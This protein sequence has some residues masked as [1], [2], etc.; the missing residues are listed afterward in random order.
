MRRG[1]KY[2]KILAAFAIPR[3]H[4]QQAKTKESAAWADLASM[5]QAFEDYFLDCDNYPH[6]TGTKSSSSGLQHLVI[7]ADSEATWAGPYMKFKK[8]T[9][10]WPY[11]PWHQPYEYEGSNGSSYTIWCKG[12]GYTSDYSTTYINP[13]LFKSP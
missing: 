4:T 10:N 13:G 5:T 12:G 7:N 8:I 11:D 6:G 2:P 1:E 3:F 9:D